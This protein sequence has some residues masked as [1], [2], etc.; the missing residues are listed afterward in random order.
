MEK[1]NG[2]TNVLIVDD[3]RNIRLTLGGILEDKGHDVVTAEDGYQAIEAVR[4]THFDAI[5]MDIKMPGINGVQTFREVKKIDPEAAV[6]MMTAYSVEDLVKEAL[7]EGAYAVMYKPFEIDRVITIIE[8]L[9]CE[10][11]LILVVD[12]QFADRET[13]KTM[14]EDKGYRVATARDGTEAI[15]M[16]GMKHYDIIFLDVRLPGMDGIQTFEQVKKIDSEATVIMMT[17]YTEEDLV[18]RAASTGAYTCLRKP[19]DMEKVVALVENIAV[20]K[21]R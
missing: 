16:V 6:I 9:L 13:L 21:K 3:L 7:E 12:D 19:F 18:K 11:V 1:S 14:L 20:E 2:K 15:E 4:K 17:G 8:E 5:F 10:R